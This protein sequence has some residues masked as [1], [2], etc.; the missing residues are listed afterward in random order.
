[1]WGNQDHSRQSKIDFP[2]TS[3]NIGSISKRLERLCASP[4]LK[5]NE[6]IIQVE[7]EGGLI[8]HL[9]QDGSSYEPVVDLTDWK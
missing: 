9:V 3:G 7:E 2:G 4:H 8:Y 6:I 5:Q 1:M